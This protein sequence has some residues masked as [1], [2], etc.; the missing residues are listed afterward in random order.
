MIAGFGGGLISHTYVEERLLASIDREAVAPF[1]RRFVRWWATVARSLGPASG[2]RAILDIAAIPL[3]HSLAYE[4][5][6]CSPATFGLI[7]DL[8]R[9]DGVLIVVPWSVPTASVWRDA[10]RAGIAAD[11]S[12]ALVC[13]GRSLRIVDCTRSWTRAAIDFDFEILATGPR[14]IATLWLLAHAQRLAGAGGGSLRAHIDDS[15]A[16]SSRVCRSLAGG[17]LSALDGVRPEHLNLASLVERVARP[18]V[19]EVILALNATVDGQTTAHYVTESIRHCDVKVTRLAH[20]VPVGGELDYL[21]EGTLSAA[22]RSR[23]AF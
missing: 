19:T 23:T 14:G 8:A 12:W 15:D 2:T 20:G 18:E 11:R 6:R 1:E 22:I 16:Q 9:E 5:L 3:M 7:A 10:A 13:S 21:D 4:P 17:V